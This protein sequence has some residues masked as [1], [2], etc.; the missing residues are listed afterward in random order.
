MSRCVHLLLALGVVGCAEVRQFDLWN[1]AVVRDLTYATPSTQPSTAPVPNYAQVD[2]FVYAILLRESSVAVASEAA[3]A[4]C[5]RAL[6]PAGIREA[7]VCLRRTEPNTDDPDL[8]IRWTQCMEDHLPTE[9]RLDAASPAERG[10]ALLVFYAAGRAVEDVEG[11]AVANAIDEARREEIRAR[12]PDVAERVAAI[13]DAVVARRT[14]RQGSGPTITPPRA[15]GGLVVTVSGG[16]ANGAFPAG[17]LFELLSLRERAIA[18]TNASAAAIEE[19]RIGATVGTSVGALLAE[20]LDLYALQDRA[21]NVSATLDRCPAFGPWQVTTPTIA[22][23]CYAASPEPR[24]PA[25]DPRT[26]DPDRDIAG[27]ALAMLHGYFTDIDESDLLCVE[28]GPVTRVA[29]LLGEVRPNLV[30]F[31]EMQTTIVD[32]IEEHFA[33]LMSDDDVP[34]AVMSVDVDQHLLLSLHDDACLVAE[35]VSMGD[36]RSSGVMASVVLPFFARPVRHVHSGLQPRGECSSW[37]DAGLRSGFPTRQALV[38]ARPAGLLEVEPVQTEV[39]SDCFPRATV[40][41]LSTDRFAAPPSGAPR[42]VMDVALRAIGEMGGQLHPTEVRLTQLEHARRERILA[43]AA[44]HRGWEPIPECEAEADPGEQRGV[45]IMTTTPLPGEGGL[46][47]QFVPADVPNHLIAAAGY[48][49]D[50]YIMRGLFTWGRRIAI[51]RIVGENDLLARIGWYALRDEMRRLAAADAR[52]PELTPWLRAYERPE[53]PA[54]HAA[55]IAAARER[56]DREMATC[57]PPSGYFVCG[58]EAP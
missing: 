6:T 40:L 41:A 25:I 37:L 44:M 28:P 43:A 17:F 55:R 19:S 26:L 57:G 4:A 29:G 8:A 38:M 30:R 48:S 27:C 24:Y 2:G 18:S 22:N 9:C 42:N 11:Y 50:R 53:C 49:F 35:G 34:R 5:F 52:A 51:A 20:I 39:G 3:V 21:P 33:E 54:H 23:G 16:S 7:G 31:D 56:V 14:A 15:H 47:W 10:D 13:L 45:G 46:A 12:V 58:A 1:R 36:C 32:R